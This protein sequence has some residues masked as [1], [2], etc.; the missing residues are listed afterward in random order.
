MIRKIILGLVLLIFTSVNSN[1]SSYADLIEKKKIF[2]GMSKV[3]L[4]DVT[5]G[6]SMVDELFLPSGLQYRDY[7]PEKNIEILTGSSR[8]MFFVFS[9]VTEKVEKYYTPGNGKL[10]SVHWDIGSAMNALNPKIETVINKPKEKVIEATKP[11]LTEEQIKI[12]KMK[13]E[14]RHIYTCK[15]KFGFR[16]GS[17]KFKDCVFEMYKVE[18]ELEKLELQKKIIE[19]NLELA[20]TRESAARSDQDRNTAL[21]ERQTLAQERTAAASAQQARIADF[22]SSQ[23]MIDDGLALM[24][25]D[26]N[27]AGQ[28][29]APRMRTTCTNLGGFI[30]CN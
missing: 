12:S 7:F 4:R 8:K 23:R 24:R 27:L 3:E 29:R 28:V 17:D 25:G 10:S 9:N 13:P 2:I 21:L 30:T 19:A 15:E 1:A 14:D 16:K 6:L 11:K 5:R 26:R 22:E 20:K 18:T